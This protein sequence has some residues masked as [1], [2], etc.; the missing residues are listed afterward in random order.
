MTNRLKKLV[1]K[2]ATSPLGKQAK[3]FVSPTNRGSSAYKIGQMGGLTVIKEPVT[4][5]R[6]QGL[7]MGKNVR[8]QEGGHIDSRGGVIIGDNTHISR[9][10]TLYSS[11]HNYRDGRVP[12]DRRLICRPVIIEENVWLGM[13]VNIVPG[14][15]IG[16]SSVVGM[17]SV[18]TKDVPPFTVVGGNP[19][20]VLRQRD[21]QAI[22]DRIEK[23]GF[24]GRR[25][26]DLDGVEHSRFVK[27]TEID[28]SKIVFILSTG[29][30]GSTGISDTL[31]Q[32]PGV[33]SN[34]EPNFNLVRL[35]AEYECGIKGEEET[36]EELLSYYR[37]T[38]FFD[39]RN[40]L[41]IES[42]QKL[43]PF[44]P[45]LN[46]IFPEAKFIWIYRNPEG[47]I[48][49]AIARNW[50]KENARENI[51]DGYLVLDPDERSM[52]T[53]LGGNVVDGIA[54][55]EWLSYNLAQRNAWYWTYWNKMIERH[56]DAIEERRTFRVNLSK[57]TDSL[58][59]IFDFIGVDKNHQIQT[60]R[61]HAM[62]RQDKKN[63]ETLEL[64][65]E[66]IK[67][68]SQQF[69]AAYYGSLTQTEE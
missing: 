14:V 20:K 37:H 66:Q 46:R 28:S 63:L 17:G 7:L 2:I 6:A 43:V 69:C 42:D 11:I 1:R 55:E 39:S 3:S 8:I 21:P 60:L 62:G 5:Q 36:Y 34:H 30:S 49:S 29:R 12:Y 45:F 54:E 33:S 48:K 25:G 19:A 56:L 50:F 15:R 22:E 41:Y 24:G 31:A 4:I 10:L 51:Y 27:L 57:L 16:E 13:N 23:Y 35:A 65:R 47:F 53:R 67:A 64:D 26:W 59:R 58:P 68:A 40:D 44:V 9:N 61:T 32:V 18:V 38:S 52:G